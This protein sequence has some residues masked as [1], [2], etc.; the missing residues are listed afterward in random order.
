MSTYDDNV[1]QATQT[2]A[3]TQ[4][5]I[6]ENFVFIKGAIGQEH[7]FDDADETNTYHLQA[8]MPNQ[9]DPGALPAGTNGMY[10]VSSARP[11]YYDSA[12]QYIHTSVPNFTVVSGTVNLNSGGATTVVTVPNETTGTYA[13]FRSGVSASSRSAFGF[14]NASNTDIL[15]GDATGFDPDITMSSSGLS[16]RARLD[17]SPS[18]AVF[19]YVVTYYTP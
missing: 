5:I 10:Y 3:Q 15:L 2:I 16:I 6:N 8:S 7:N 18:P 19:K 17:G 4:P 13:L 12:A 14:F 9:A 11:K 1:P